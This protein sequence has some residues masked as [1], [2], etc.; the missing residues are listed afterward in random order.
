MSSQGYFRTMLST[1]WHVLMI[2]KCQVTNYYRY[3]NVQWSKHTIFPSEFSG[4]DLK[5]GN[6]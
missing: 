1:I 6:K 5:G 2:I 4:E 3:Q